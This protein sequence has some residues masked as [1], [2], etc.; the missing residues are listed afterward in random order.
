MQQQVIIRVL[1][2]APTIREMPAA[3]VHQNNN[4]KVPPF[5]ISDINKGNNNRWNCSL[6]RPKEVPDA[7]TPPPLP[8]PK[9]DKCH[10]IYI[11]NIFGGE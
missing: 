7:A 4:A 11:Y 6:Y 1:A 3:P 9:K 10:I 5:S 8:P 2:A